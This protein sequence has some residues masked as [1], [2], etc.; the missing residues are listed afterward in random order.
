MLVRLYRVA[1]DITRI[2]TLAANSMMLL[3]NV[4]RILCG[5]LCRGIHWN[6]LHNSVVLL[7]VVFCRGLHMF[8][9]EISLIREK[10]SIY[11]LVLGQIECS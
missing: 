4:L 11:L 2:P 10:E 8:Q 6:W 9:R 5:V 7:A 1:S 3:C